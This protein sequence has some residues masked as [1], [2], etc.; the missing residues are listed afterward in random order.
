MSRK[1]QSIEKFIS[2]PG[3]VNRLIDDALAQLF[4]GSG[5]RSSGN[6]TSSGTSSSGN[7]PSAYSSSQND[8]NNIPQASSNTVAGGV[9]GL[10][11][12]GLNMWY[13]SRQ[14]EIAYE[15]QNE[16]Y[17]NHLS[18]GAKV[19]EY[20][21][22]GLNPYSLS[23]AGVGA[24]SAPSVQQA[25]PVDVAGT[26]NGLVSTLLEYKLKSR[27]LDIQQQLADNDTDR[28]GSTIALNQA[29]ITKIF[30]ESD[31]VAVETFILGIQSKY[32]DEKERAALDNLLKDLDVKNATINKT[33]AEEA[34]T[35]IEASWIPKMN[36]SQIN[37]NS[38]SARASNARAAIDEYTY[39]YME[40]HDGMA[41]P[42]GIVAAIAGLAMNLT[43]QG[44]RTNDL[45]DPFGPHSPLGGT[46]NGLKELFKKRR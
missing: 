9:L 46:W 4:V 10:I 37:L 24:T 18:M 19:Q 15:R 20:K 30:K 23:G 33:E 44:T 26:V 29:N 3:G 31:K 7:T 8:S 45:I 35:W 13:N 5:K 21:D 36:Q 25:S 38:A 12:T 14:A 16:F 22:A 42:D 40:E 2:S 27:E 41:P 17:D 11:S 1:R 34:K 43:E 39:T 28:T 32:T 6:Q